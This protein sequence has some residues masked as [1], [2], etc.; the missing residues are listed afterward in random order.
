MKL[1]KLLISATYEEEPNR[2]TIKFVYSKSY[3]DEISDKE[4]EVTYTDDSALSMVD[5]GDDGGDILKSF[6]SNQSRDKFHPIKRTRKI[7]T[8][9]SVIKEPS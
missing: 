3:S 8:E 9:N 7:R 5:E 1:S 2:I 6:L 4:V